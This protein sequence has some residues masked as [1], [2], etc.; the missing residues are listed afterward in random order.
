MAIIRKA[1]FAIGCVAGVLLAIIQYIGMFSDE[2][3]PASVIA[4]LY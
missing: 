1:L 3:A 2:P 4:L